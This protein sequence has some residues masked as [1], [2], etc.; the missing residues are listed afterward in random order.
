MLLLIWRVLGDAVDA[1]NPVDVLAAVT[2]AL[3]L[4][5]F[6]VCAVPLWVF[7]AREHRL[8]NRWTLLLV[9]GGALCLGAATL[10]APS[11]S[12]LSGRGVRMLLAGLVYAGVMFVLHLLTRGG[13]GMGDVKLAA[14][15]GVYT[16]WLSWD[17]LLA[18]VVFGFLIGG[19]LALLLVLTRRATRSTRIAFGPSLLLGAMV[20]LLLMDAS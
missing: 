5:W 10:L 7:D 3:G 18:S 19:V 20:P 14:G 13:M 15:L 17:G 11:A 8:P 9:G 1:G 4:V 6:V 16:G 2:A 12:E